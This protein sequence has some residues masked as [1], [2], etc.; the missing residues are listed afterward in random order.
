MLEGLL[1]PSE[2][3][4]LDKVGLRTPR[5]HARELS[6]VWLRA[7]HHFQNL[8]TSVGGER[9]SIGCVRGGGGG[10]GEGR[11]IFIVYNDLRRKALGARRRTLE[12]TS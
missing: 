2:S 12:Y 9:N 5:H 11:L 10:G 7:S 1:E 3:S 8:R 6:Y 4:S